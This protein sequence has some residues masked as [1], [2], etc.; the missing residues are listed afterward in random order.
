MPE[1]DALIHPV[2]LCGGAGS[3]LWPLSRQ[4]F[5]KQF[6]PLAGQQTM[7]QET[8]SR[9]EPGTIAAPLL[10]TNEEHRFIVAEQLRALGKP[11]GEI[12]LEP[13]GR[14]TAPAV[15]I[16]ALLICAHDPDGLML[17]MPSDHV[18]RD[19]TAFSTAVATAARSARAGHLVTFGITPSYPE[20]GYGYIRS[21]TALAD[22]AGVHSVAQFVEKPDTTTAAR[23]LESGDYYW[24]SGIFL[25]SARVF[26]DELRRFQ[27]HIVTACQAA[28]DGATR[29]L[30]FLRLAPEPFAACPA[31]SIDYAVMERTDHAVVVPVSMGWSDVGA[32]TALWELGDQDPAGNVVRGDV[33]LHDSRNCYVRSEEGLLTAVV[34]VEDLVV[35]VVDDAVLISHKDKAQDVKVIVER[36]KAAKRPEH[37]I[38]STVYRP[39]GS[40]R[41]VDEGSRFQVK[42]ITVN[43]GAKLSLQMHHHRAEHWVVVEGTAKVTRGEET[44]LLHE[45]Q[46]TYIPLGMVHRLENP[47]KVPLRLIEVQSGTYLGEDDIIRLEDT[48]GRA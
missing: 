12:I 8:L 37:E 42:Q 28:I 19:R 46:S 13:A 40:F 7:L 45:N 4:M 26:L 33:M 48:F 47:G 43:P 32:W 38:H 1:D 9:L 3:R 6:L 44:L 27:P 39:W 18:V 41:G 21:G 31:D 11:A 34:G 23:Y 25:F 10:I 35:V 30:D 20:T 16:A 14:G 15:C 17:V 2:V 24:N 36:L 29:D 22:I 5:P